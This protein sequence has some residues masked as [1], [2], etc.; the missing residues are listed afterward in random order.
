MSCSKEQNKRFEEIY[1]KRKKE[2]KR[3]Y[4]VE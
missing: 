2:K 1:K 3:A 4:Y